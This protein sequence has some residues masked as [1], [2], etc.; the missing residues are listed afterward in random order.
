MEEVSAA[1]AKM[2]PELICHICLDYLNDPGTIDCSHNFCDSC[3]CMS[4]KD[5]Q[6]TFP[7]PM[8]RQSCQEMR[9]TANAQ[10]GRL[11]DLA[12]LPHSSGSRKM[13][14]A[15]E[16][17]CEEHRQGMSLFCEED[18][19]LVCPLCAQGPAHQG[20]HVRSVAEAVAH[21]QR[22]G[23]C[24]GSLTKQLAEVQKRKPEEL[25]LVSKNIRVLHFPHLRME[26]VSAALAKMQPELICLV[27]LDYLNDPVTIDCSQNFCDSC[28]R[29]SWKDLQDTFPCPMCQQSRLE[30]RISANAQ[31]GRLVDLVDPAQI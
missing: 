22:V 14:R 20:H 16:G 27:C 30:M 7:C 3:I 18:Q 11:V 8:S 19:E 5:L 26:K 25:D 29:M 4:W 12:K 10:L 6:N 23:E 31:L 9:V 13:A 15:E 2:Q 28:I 1:L 21:R 24:I 17:R